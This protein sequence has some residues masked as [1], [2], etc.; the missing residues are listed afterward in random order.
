MSNDKK[1]L[2][3]ICSVNICK[4]KEMID[5]QYHLIKLSEVAALELV[6]IRVTIA[7]SI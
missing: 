5:T 2:H 7:H 4:H 3:I 6:I 1:M